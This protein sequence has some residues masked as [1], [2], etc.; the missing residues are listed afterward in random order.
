M[1]SSHGLQDLIR[2]SGLTCLAPNSVAQK[3][4]KPLKR[5]PLGSPT[6]GFSTCLLGLFERCVFEPT[7]ISANVHC[8][9]CVWR[10]GVDR[11]GA[12]GPLCGHLAVGGGAEVVPQHCFAICGLQPL[13]LE[14]I[15]ALL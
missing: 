3:I 2:V 1:L 7:K 8:A 15:A 11:T 13:W 10:Q 5:V 6:S 9:G 14:V 12:P 4:T